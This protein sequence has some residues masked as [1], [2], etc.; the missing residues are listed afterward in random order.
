MLNLPLKPSRNMNPKWAKLSVL[1][2]RA[3]KK[4]VPRKL[5]PEI[6]SKFPVSLKLKKFGRNPKCDLDCA[7]SE[8]KV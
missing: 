1:T 7:K 6:L 3:Y 2:R 4:S 5:F 8:I